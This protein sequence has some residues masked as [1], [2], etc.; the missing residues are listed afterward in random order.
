[1]L[2]IDVRLRL[3]GIGGLCGGQFAYPLLARIQKH[4][5]PRAR[6]LNLA[7]EHSHGLQKPLLSRH[8]KA[9]P[10]DLH[11]VVTYEDAIALIGGQVFD[12]EF[13]QT[14]NE[15]VDFVWAGLQRVAY[16]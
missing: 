1:M 13:C 2:S 8:L 16:R 7:L 9:R 15:L 11:L 3:D 12:A 14:L 10:A 4:A 5:L 6:D